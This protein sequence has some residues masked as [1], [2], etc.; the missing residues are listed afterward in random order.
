M[1]ETY[2]PENRVDI[3]G[4]VVL[5]VCVKEPVNHGMWE[6]GQGG[7]DGCQEEVYL[8]GLQKKRGGGRGRR[9]ERER[10][11]KEKEKWWLKGGD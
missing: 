11:E 1:R 6:G 3:T 7:E 2:L 8:I 10:G 5:A 4:G 9:G